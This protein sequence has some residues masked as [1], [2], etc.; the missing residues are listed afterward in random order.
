MKNKLDIIALNDWGLGNI[1]KPLIISGPCSAETEEQ[2]L[3]TALQLK[4]NGINI[5]RAGI[6]KPRTKPGSFEGV[7]SKGLAWLTKVKKETEMLVCT[8]VANAKHVKEALDAEIDILWIG[9]R[10]TANPF[11]VQD[12]ADALQGVNI[13][14]FIKNPINP[15]VDLWEGA[16]ERIYKAGI[17]RIGVIHRG[18]SS[19]EHSIFRNVPQWQIAIDLKR[20]IPNI[21]TINDPS[22]IGGK[23]SLIHSISQKAMDLDFDGLMIESH[24]EPDNAWSDA[25]QQVT[26]GALNDILNSIIIRDAKTDGAFLDTLENLRLQI[27]KI[28]DNIMDLLQNRMTISSDIG[29]YKKENNMTI[30]QQDRWVDL[31]EK[32][33][34]KGESRELSKEFISKVYKIIHQESIN[35]QT[36]I[37]NQQN[38]KDKY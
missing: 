6:W 37:M 20:R 12:I 24:I 34:N 18:F 36:K 21:V 31:L 27:D 5:Y 28:D 35:S 26:P 1:N 8:E 16:V 3:E 2:V 23:R 17:R 32:N 38:K 22:H 13:P 33:K 15:D 30:L 29:K 25:K 11:A 10:T 7:G 9:A 14:I 19:Y 4:A